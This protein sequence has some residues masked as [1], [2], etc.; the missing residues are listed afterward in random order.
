[1]YSKDNPRDLGT[2][3]DYDLFLESLARIF[4]D[5][6]HVLKRKKYMVVVV[7]NL[8]EP[9]GRMVPLAWDLARRIDDLWTFKGEKIWCQENKRLG[10][11]GYPSEFVLN[12]HHHYCLIFKKEN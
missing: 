9:G 10:I 1:V 11:W 4:A 7:Q 3:A 2:V 8:R 6:H 12:V 5:I